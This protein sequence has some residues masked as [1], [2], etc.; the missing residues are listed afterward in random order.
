VTLW[1]DQVH[2]RFVEPLGNTEQ[3][4]SPD[5]LSASTNE[6]AEVCQRLLLVARACGRALG[7]VQRRGGRELAKQR[8]PRIAPLEQQADGKRAAMI[9]ECG[10]SVPDDASVRRVLR[11][12]TFSGGD[13]FYREVNLCK[14]CSKT[15]LQHDKT[16]KRKKVMLVLL[17]VAGSAAGFAYSYFR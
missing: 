3:A 13:A 10:A 12:G 6:I 7:A 15:L 11:T 1:A 2:L 4:A 14:R 16:A 9:H 17:L 5:L 8:L